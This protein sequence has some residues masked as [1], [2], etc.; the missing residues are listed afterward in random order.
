VFL[1]NSRHPLDYDPHLVTLL[2]LSYPKVTRAICRV[3]LVL[4]SQR[5]SIF[6]LSISVDLQYGRFFS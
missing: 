6:Y 5:L 3:P 2:G 1:L 4:L